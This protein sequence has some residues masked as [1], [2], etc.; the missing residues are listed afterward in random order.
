MNC[1]RL[2]LIS[3][4][5]F[6]N[7]FFWKWALECNWWL[8]SRGGGGFAPQCQQVSSF[9][10]ASN[11]FSY[12]LG[13]HYWKQRVLFALIGKEVLVLVSR[14][15]LFF[16][17]KHFLILWIYST[18]LSGEEPT[19]QRAGEPGIGPRCCFQGD[20]YQTY[21]SGLSSALTRGKKIKPNRIL[22]WFRVLHW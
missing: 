18:C 12:G 13:I 17:V 16:R 15:V 19:E 8:N 14:P 11:P 7:F 22:C 9:Q 5:I 20:G 1:P 4:G 2:E 6:A 3:A 10:K 21:G